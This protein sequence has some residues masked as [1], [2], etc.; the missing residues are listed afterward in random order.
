MPLKMV[1]VQSDCWMGFVV[2]AFI[3][4]ICFV[5]SL[6]AV[7]TQSDSPQRQFVSKAEMKG[8]S[9]AVYC[10]RF[11]PCGKFIATGMLALRCVPVILVH[12]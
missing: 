2:R 9:A 7:L 11:S 5:L 1:V 6:V 10:G 8:H 4:S 12:D 3:D